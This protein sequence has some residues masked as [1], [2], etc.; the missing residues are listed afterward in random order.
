MS[1]P[2]ATHDSISAMFL[3]RI[4]SSTRHRMACCG[5]IVGRITIGFLFS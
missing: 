2:C 5:D 1:A 3:V 4:V